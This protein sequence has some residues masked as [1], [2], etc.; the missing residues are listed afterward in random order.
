MKVSI[1]Q[2]AVSIFA[3]LAVAACTAVYA[4]EQAAGEEV[5]QEVM[6]ELQRK[7]AAPVSVDFHQTPIEDVVRIIAEQADVD[8][9]SSPKV[10]GEVNA[11]LTDVPLRE[12]L[13]NILAAHGYGYVVDKN[14][15]RIGPVDEIAQKNELLVNRIYRVT[16]ADV[17][18]VENALSKF[19]SSRGSLS[20]NPGTSNIIVTDSESKIKAIDIFME[21]I[22]RITPQILVEARIYDLT[23]K[24]RLDLG[25][26]WQAGRNT[27]YDATDGITAIGTNPTGTNNPFLTGVFEGATGKTSGVSGALRF[28][29]LTA[30]L[31]IDT[32]IKA[33]HNKIDAKLLANPRILVLDNQEAVIK[34][35]SEL[36]YQELTETSAGGSIGTTQFREVGVEL[37][38]T[39]H[40]TRDGMIRLNLK[41]KFSVQ[42][43]EVVVVGTTDNQFPQPVVDRREADTT[44]LI[45]D[46]QTVVLGGL[47]KKDITQQVNKVPFFGDLPIAGALFKFEGE[48]TV[49]SELVVFITPWLIEKPVMSKAEQRQYEI[50]EFEGPEPQFTRPELKE[51]EQEQE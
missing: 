26:E 41:P 30:G 29:L 6:T 50:T 33:Q 12:A 24:D 32:V 11:T 49:I 45:E 15:I 21:E 13:D 7:M 27:T 14:M 28:G 43:D 10:I 40:L 44:L 9:I 35:I 18:E 42:T 5:E 51:Q 16:Y 8:I 47:R 23:S 46:G 39:P 2:R 22:D 3:I 20:S 31:D 48:D 25:V 36:P 37:Q 1:T 38:V 4:D 19:I 17:G 34:I